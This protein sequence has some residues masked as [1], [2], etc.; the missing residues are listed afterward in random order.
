MKKFLIVILPALLAAAALYYFNAPPPG[1]TEQTFT[2]TYGETT[3][4]IA[5]NL[6]K[7]NLIRSR[8]FFVYS[9]RLFWRRYVRAG[10]YQIFSDMSSIDIL[11][12][13][14]RGDVLSR[15][16]TI[17]EG[18]NQ[19]QIADRLE[20]NEICAAGEFLGYASDMGYLKTL[21]IDS[22]SAEGYLFPDTYVFPESSDPRNIIAAMHRKMKA[23]LGKRPAYGP[24][25]SAHEILT[26]ASLVE[27]EARVYDER[28]FISS[29]FHN[30]LRRKMRLDCDPT[31]R[32]AVKKFT[33]P[34]TVSDLKSDS[35]YN[36]YRRTGLPPAPICSP[37]RESILAAMYPK[38]TDYLYFVS[39]NDGSHKFSR[40]L[41]EHN[42]AVMLYQRRR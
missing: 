13:L 40:T 31:V 24:G 39:K 36:T 10:R 2:V 32:Y 27:K 17:P 6:H 11:M 29:V 33:G 41:R 37:G 25:M 15:K 20:A 35:P 1:M 23:V 26:L 28:E 30:R 3:R 38:K 22:P 4:I 34:I 21:G 12:K 42:E 8:S 5:L 19:F 9:S 14:T 18:F 7:N 16:I